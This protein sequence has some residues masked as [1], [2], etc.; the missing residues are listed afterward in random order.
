MRLALT[1]YQNN[2]QRLTLDQR[3]SQRHP[4]ARLDGTNNV[5]E[6]V[7]GWFIMKR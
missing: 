5:A 7:I 4:A 6:R 1:L 2:W 3:W